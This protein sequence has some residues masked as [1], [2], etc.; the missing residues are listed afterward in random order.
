M[1]M[2]AQ[3]RYFKQGKP[4]TR[5][6]A[7]TKR[8]EAAQ[9]NTEVA[10]VKRRRASVEAALVSPSAPAQVTLC[11]LAA[12]DE[13]DTSALHPAQEKLMKAQKQKLA[14]RKTQAFLD[15]VLLPHEKTDEVA[16]AAETEVKERKRRQLE[17]TAKGLRSKA[18]TKKKAFPELKDM[19]YYIVGDAELT[20]SMRVSLAR[21]GCVQAPS[22]LEATLF[23]AKDVADIGTRAK[24]C[25]VMQGALVITP[26]GID[27]NG[28]ALK[29]C[30]GNKHRRFVFMTEKF[31]TK[32]A[33]A[34]QKYF[35]E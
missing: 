5:N 31:R 18:F 15:G 11:A 12:D 32:H 24:W 21:R 1:N 34:V 30:R 8:K 26:N 2:F 14:V 9:A 22:R 25:A 16:N 7:G 27:Q 33:E 17:R 13:D 3:E 10:F 20:D 29:Y 28:P 4:S 23:I 6:D 19:P 35:K